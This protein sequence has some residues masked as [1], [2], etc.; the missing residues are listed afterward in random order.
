MATPARVVIW[1]LVGGHDYVHHM[2]VLRFIAEVA[3][4]TIW[5]ALRHPE[6]MVD[7]KRC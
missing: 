1:S 4:L 7:L 3:K 2:R 6:F 5:V